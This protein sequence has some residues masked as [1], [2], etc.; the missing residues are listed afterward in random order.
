MS[1]TTNS[2]APKIAGTVGIDNIAEIKDILDGTMRG[3]I[4]RQE[5]R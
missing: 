2:V 5:P 1:V 4:C 3:H